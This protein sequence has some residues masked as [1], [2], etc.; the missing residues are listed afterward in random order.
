MM[1]TSFGKNECES[2]CVTFGNNSQGQVLDF[3]EIAI[4]IEQ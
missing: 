2:D 3:G 4:T 1:F